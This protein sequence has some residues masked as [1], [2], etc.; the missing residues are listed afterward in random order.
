MTYAGICKSNQQTR[1]YDQNVAK[2]TTLFAYEKML[3]HDEK[4][5]FIKRESFNSVE[6]KYNFVM[7]KLKLIMRNVNL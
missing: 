2:S 5:K 3:I 1:N 7:R 6:K 4:R